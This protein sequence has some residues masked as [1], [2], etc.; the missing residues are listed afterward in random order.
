MASVE[1]PQVSNASPSE[2]VTPAEAGVQ[3]A[4]E[5]RILGNDGVEGAA[6]LSVGA[7]GLE[8]SRT[9]VNRSK[10][11]RAALVGAESSDGAGLALTLCA[12]VQY[13]L[14]SHYI[15]VVRGRSE[16]VV[17]PAGARGAHGAARAAFGRAAFI[18][19]TAGATMMRAQATRG[20]GA[21]RC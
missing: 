9:I 2:V 14:H 20:A 12:T 5:S 16:H 6:G 8:R 18:R 7:R 10:R 21:N 3:E 4:L 17:R 15:G 19:E 1:A 11:L 13:L